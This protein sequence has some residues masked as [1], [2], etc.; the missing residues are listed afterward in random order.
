MGLSSSQARLLHLTGR[1]HQIEY[2]AQKLE[3]QK[4]QL[5]NESSRVYEDYENALEAT[6][7]QY[8]ALNQ[9]GSITFKD[10]TMNA[11]Q[12]GI[13]GNWGGETSGEILFLQDQDNKIIV[14]PT[15]ANKYGLKTTENET[16]DLDTFIS[17]TTGKSKSTKEITK[18]VPKYRQEKHMVETQDTSINN[19]IGSN[20]VTNTV[21]QNPSSILS[22]L[23]PVKNSSSTV[24]VEYNDFSDKSVKSHPVNT[25]SLQDINNATSFTSGST[26]KIS[27]VEGMKK[28]QSIVNNN[29]TLEG[30]TFVLSNNIDMS[31]V[32]NWQGIGCVLSTYDERFFRGTFDGNGYVISNLTGSQGL[33]EGVR[34]NGTIKNLGV[35]NVNIT[36]STQNWSNTGTGGIAGKVFEGATIE[37]CYVT[38]TITAPYRVGGIVGENGN[39]WA[40]GTI[41]NC[42]ANVT[43]KSTDSTRADIGGISASSSG[44]IIGCHVTGQAIPS[45]ENVGGI[46]AYCPDNSTIIDCVTSFKVT[47][48]NNVGTV[49]GSL[50]TGATTNISNV[51][52]DDDGV[53]NICG[54]TSDSSWTSSQFATNITT[55]SVNPSDYTGGF[56]SN[57]IGALAKSGEKTD[58]I[59]TTKVKNYIKN[60]Y[61]NSN[62][63]MYIANIN[64]YLCNYMNGS[65]STGSFIDDLKKDI[66]NNTISSTTS[67]SYQTTYTSNDNIII[68]ND[69]SDTW[70]PVYS[71]T[72]G[73]IEIPTV[74]TIAKELYYNFVQKD[75]TVTESQIS[76]WL[77]NFSSS[78]EGKA[79][80]ANIN[81]M[82]NSGSDL[83]AILTAIKGNN[84]AYSNASKYNS[85]DWDISFKSSDDNIEPTY[86]SKTAPKWDGTYVDVFDH[87]E[88]EPDH[89]EEY[90]DTTDPDIARAIAMYSLAKRC[91]VTVVTEEQASS[92]DYLTNIINAGQAVFTTFNPSK[93]SSFANLSEN[94]RT[95]MSDTD[96]NKFMGIENT[97]VSVKTSLREVDNEK[98][99]QESRSKIRS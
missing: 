65:S 20:K 99:T 91:G 24:T 44:T 30:V 40:G 3:A 69:T 54:N 48:S 35:E 78:D 56:Y 25:S 22:A 45:G 59:D 84:T 77:N 83:S 71:T 57:I 38:G 32:T 67:S 10:A 85:T 73:K 4:L 60:L 43:L 15:V 80:L 36:K 6:K 81:E 90:W 12:N 89:T 97:S 29:N 75:S 66:K 51:V 19:I 27:D 74:N 82:I 52:Y 47:G 33:F 28:L 11:M 94:E 42:N 79:T 18:Q 62:N 26:Y 76:N 53:H 92:V 72:K 9:D 55:P 58:E 49:L 8:R 1:M 87:Y 46:L 5:A 21:K 95:N 98:K 93:V 68:S 96:F 64:E 14:T 41:K 86:G 39:T 63:S 37:N 16:R 34:R 88:E 17:E 70:N 31:S 61:T 2:K 50:F 7:I 23:T 13:V